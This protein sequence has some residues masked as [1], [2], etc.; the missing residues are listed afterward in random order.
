MNSDIK[1]YVEYLK[2]IFNQHW[3]IESVRK[4]FDNILNGEPV[5]ESEANDDATYLKYLEDLRKSLKVNYRFMNIFNED[6]PK[7]IEIL[8]YKTYIRTLKITNITND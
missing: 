2:D 6:K 7:S 3:D 1:K 4:R 8:D 5:A